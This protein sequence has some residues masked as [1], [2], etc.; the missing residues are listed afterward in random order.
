MTYADAAFHVWTAFMVTAEG[1]G[2]LNEDPRDPGNW[3]S[4]MCGI[5]QCHGTKYGISAAAY[6][7]LD[8][9]DLTRDAALTLAMRDYWAPCRCGEL[10]PALALIVADAAY[11]SGPNT[12]KRALQRAVL[13]AADGIIGP[14]T[15]AAVAS[16]A[17]G[18]SVVGLRSGL[19]DLLCEFI[20]QREVFETT[21]PTFRTFGLGWTRRNVR[22]LMLAT[23]LL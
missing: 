22:A 6:P 9:M 11:T 20:A 7:D 17:A 2:K 4:G 18:R 23:A 13:V 16:H 8:I 3:T 1:E 15:L 14:V 10:P 21:L 12:A 19:E 5:G